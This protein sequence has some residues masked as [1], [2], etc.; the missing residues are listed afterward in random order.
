MSSKKIVHELS[1]DDL[2]KLAQ[3]SEKPVVMDGPT[4]AAKFTYA[5]NIRH[6]EAKI[7]AELIYFTYKQWRGWDK[8][9]QPKPYFFRDFTKQFEK[10][11][12]N[13]GISYLLDPRPFDLS[14][15]QF[16]L[17]KKDSREIRAK[18]KK[19]TTKT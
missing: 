14:K 15:E 16:W 17:M 4:E 12:T 6:G 11:R 7:S 8:R 1:I 10:V 13:E 2:I 3:G 9:P 19:K 5:L 18:Q